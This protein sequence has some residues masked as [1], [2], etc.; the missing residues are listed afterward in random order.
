M[1]DAVGDT[2]KNRAFWEFLWGLSRPFIFF[3]SQKN[4]E[5]ACI[6]VMY[7]TTFL[8]TVHLRNQMLLR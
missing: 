1:I 5:F 8:K 4:R 7:W 6:L 2:I 3:H